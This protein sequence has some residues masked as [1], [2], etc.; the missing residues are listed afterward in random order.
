M[1]DGGRE[2][3]FMVVLCFAVARRWL[4]EAAWPAAVMAAM[5]E[6]ETVVAGGGEGWLSSSSSLFSVFELEVL[7]EVEAGFCF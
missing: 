4:A 6:G 3:M 7:K 1:G 2:E 5:D